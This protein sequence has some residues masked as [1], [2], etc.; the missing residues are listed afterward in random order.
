[1][2]HSDQA[3][4]IQEIAEVFL[5]H[6]AEHWMFLWVNGEDVPPLPDTLLRWIADDLLSLSIEKHQLIGMILRLEHPFDYLPHDQA[7]R[8][9]SFMRCFRNSGGWRLIFP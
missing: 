2:S 9:Q 4:A 8:I 5:K 1:M 6:E 3:I 7:T